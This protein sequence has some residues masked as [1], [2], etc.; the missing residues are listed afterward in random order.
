VPCFTLVELWDVLS[1][2][3]FYFSFFI[4]LF[5]FVLLCFALFCF[6]LFC[7]FRLISLHFVR[8]ARF[9]SFNFFSFSSSFSFLFLFIIL[10]L[11]FFSPKGYRNCLR[12][13]TKKIQKTMGAKRKTMVCWLEAPNPPTSAPKYAIFS[14]FVCFVE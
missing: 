7:S 6:A 8:L 9:V 4:A 14:Y 2:F 5:C 13:T 1:Y 12:P 10:F 3:T 11:F